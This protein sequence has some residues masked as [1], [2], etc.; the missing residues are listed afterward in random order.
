MACM[1]EISV[2]FA[3]ETFFKDGCSFFYQNWQSE[4]HEGK[5]AS[6]TMS[7]SI[8]TK[9]LQIYL[10]IWRKEI[11]NEVNF[12]FFD[13][14][15]LQTWWPSAIIN[16][17]AEM[18]IMFVKGLFIYLG[19]QL[20][21]KDNAFGKRRNQSSPERVAHDISA[22]NISESLCSVSSKRQIQFCQGLYSEGKRSIDMIF[23]LVILLP[24]EAWRE[25]EEKL[26]PCPV[27]MGYIITR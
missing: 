22:A 5:N 21:D 7:S 16:E 24:L 9:A 10:T 19:I 14:S 26:C 3:I 27:Y 6:K 12:I 20:W 8:T 25:D 15:P 13:F 4:L 23:K 18:D 2:T 1:I 17:E 11:L